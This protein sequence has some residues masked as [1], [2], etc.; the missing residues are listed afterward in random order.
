M[1]ASA[2]RAAASGMAVSTFGSGIERLIV[3]SRNSS[4]PPTSIL[5]PAR[6][7]ARSSGRSWRCAIASARA[8][9]RSSSRSRHARPVAEFSTP[10]KRRFSDIAPIV[11]PSRSAKAERPVNAGTAGRT[12]IAG[13]T[14]SP[15]FAGDDNQNLREL[16]ELAVLGDDAAHGAGG[17]AHDHGFGLDDAVAEA[18]AAQ[19]AAVGHAGRREQ[20]IAAHHVLDLIFLARVL[21]AHLGG[22]LALL[23]GIDDE[24]ALHLA[25]DAAQ[26][27]RREHAFGRAAD[28]EI[29]VDAGFARL[30]GMD[31]PGHVAVGDQ[32]DRRADLAH[33][34][35]DV[36]VA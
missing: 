10:R 3:G 6:M 22:A 17:R 9:P 20:T 21:D 19:H 18:H 5:R 35:D 12:Q 8:E 24:A 2:M 32:T 30:G 29:N 16:V 26:R 36:G 23:V 11:T 31:D 33:C 25:A 7:R 4:T 13:I 28:A 1:T 27:R 15:A 14:G 34:R